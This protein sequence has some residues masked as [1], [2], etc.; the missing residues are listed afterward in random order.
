MAEW[1]LKLLYDGNCP[2]CRREVDWLKTRNRRRLLRF[3]DIAD[4]QFD[5]ARYGLTRQQVDAQL[6]GVLP[7]GRVV[8]G[9]AAVRAAYRAIGL[10][11]L[12]APTALPGVR[13]FTDRM[14]AAFAR[15]RISL[16]Q[17]FGRRC[18]HGVCRSES[19]PAG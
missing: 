2:F 7:N 14:Y 16:G 19:P 3:E 17:V 13:W 11:W 18:E 15:N 6:H 1:K 12:V 10:G 5:P 4:S 9:M 8:R